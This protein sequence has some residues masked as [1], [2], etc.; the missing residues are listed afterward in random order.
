MTL[1]PTASPVHLLTDEFA[2][3]LQENLSRYSV[4]LDV[5][6]QTRLRDYYGHVM[7]WNKRL[8]LVASCSPA[9]F[10]TR[11]VLESLCALPVLPPDASVVDVGS[12]AGLPIIPCLI[13]RPDLRVTLIEASGKKVMFLREVLRRVA[14]EQ[15]WQVIHKRFEEIGMPPAEVVTCRALER[16]NEMLPQLV[17][18]SAPLSTLLLFGGLGLEEAIKRTGLHFTSIHLPDSTQRFLFIV[19]HHDPTFNNESGKRRH[20]GHFEKR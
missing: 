13:A 16:F 15:R 19:H 17:R 6:T 5:P 10:A 8:H 3:A 12:G 2:H 11:H 9:E 7:T 4:Q 1:Q 18:W 20:N 14:R